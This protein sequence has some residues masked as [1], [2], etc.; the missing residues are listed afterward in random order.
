MANALTLA[1]ILLVIPFAFAFLANA[2]W[3]MNAA[4]VIFVIAAATDF[5]D[6]WAARRFGTVSA[7]GAAL[8]PVADKLLIAAALIL[9]IRNGVIRE[10]GI[11]AVLVILL[12]E[13]LVSGLREAVAARGGVLKVTGAAKFKTTAQLIAAGLLIA[14]APNGLLGDPWR[15]AAGGA[16]WLAAIL[17]FATGADYVVKAM[18][19]L[20]G[21]PADDHKGG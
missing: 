16:L 8:D 6:G 4:L 13:M 14:A 20:S 15:P 17:T 3:N 10:A 1:R 18:K 21:K 5:L 12:R 19:L 7:R 2:P 11:V 9:L